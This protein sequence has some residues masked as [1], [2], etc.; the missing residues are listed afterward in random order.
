MP[1]ER[2]TLTELKDRT[3]SDLEAHL[4]GA[5]IQLRRGNVQVLSSV[6]AGAAHG[7]YGYLERMALQILPDT[8]EVEFLERQG[9]LWGISRKPAAKAGGQIIITGANGSVIPAGTQF[10]RSDAL[11]FVTTQEG[12]ISGGSA[13]VGLIAQEAGADGDTAEG[14]IFALAPYVPGLDQAATIAT[15]GLTG[16]ADA[17]TDDALRARIITRMQEPPAGGAKHDYEA[18][19]LQISG[20]TRAY[21]YPERMGA[22]TVGVTILTDDAEGGPIPGQPVIDEVQAHIDDLRPVTASVTVF[23]CSANPVD[24]DIRLQGVDTPEVRAAVQAELADLFRRESEPEGAVLIS[25]VREAISVAAGEYDHVINSPSA[26][27][28]AGTGELLTVGSFT[29]EDV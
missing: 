10:D 27:V 5:D 15:G 25:H 6:Q 1:F 3:N 29:W 18:W 12:T 20:V 14:S 17:E 2:P 21:V 24:F 11:R 23:A 9:S 16:G 26:N 22:G 13:T 19:A 4:P 8:A 7:L 28:S